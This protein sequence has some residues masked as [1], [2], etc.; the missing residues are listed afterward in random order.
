M[1]NEHLIGK[2]FNEMTPQR[3]TMEIWREMLHCSFMLTD[4]QRGTF[5]TRFYSMFN[6]GEISN[7]DDVYKICEQVRAEYPAK[8]K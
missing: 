5:Y 6:A 7:D 8:G 4:D 3:G 1:T 2:I